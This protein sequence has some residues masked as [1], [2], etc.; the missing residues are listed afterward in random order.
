VLFKEEIKARSD[1]GL[2]EWSPS[3]VETG[4][5]I[6]LNASRIPDDYLDLLQSTTLAYLATIGPKGDPQVSA[7]WLMWDGTQHF[8][9]FKNKRQKYRNVL[10]EPRVAIAISDPADPC[11]AL[12]IRGVVARIDDDRAFG[13]SNAVSQRY[14]ARDSTFKETGAAEERIVILVAPERM[15]PFPP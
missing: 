4:K 8:F 3:Q 9:A 6:H 1:W 7:V 10:R 13:F 2:E 5:D 12:E 15:I 14:L 11:H